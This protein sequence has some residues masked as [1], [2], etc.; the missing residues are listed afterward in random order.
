MYII[1]VAHFLLI[2]A[3]LLAGYQALSGRAVFGLTLSA[4]TLSFAGLFYAFIVSDF[5]VGLV[6]AHSHTEKP[7]LYKIA[8]V[9][10]NHEGSM[11]LWAWVLALFG[12]MMGLSH[13]KELTP[14]AQRVQSGLL[15]LFLLFIA[16]TS[17]P[18]WRQLP[19]PFEGDG[20][21]PLLQDPALAAHPPLLYLG[22]VGFSAVFSLAVAGLWHHYMNHPKYAKEWAA[23]ARPWALSAWTFLTVGIGLGSYW[24]YYEL[25]WG[26]W[27]FWDPVENAS[28]MPWLTGTALLHSI[29]VMS[30]RGLFARWVTFLSLVTFGLSLLGTFLVRSGVLISVHTFAADPDRGLFILLILAISVGGAFIL[31]A[32]KNRRETPSTHIAPV[33]KESVILL[34]N[35]VLF[36]AATTVLLGTLY[37]VMTDTLLSIGPPFYEATIL[38]MMIPIL[39]VCGLVPALNWQRGHKLIT[40]SLYPAV[41]SLAAFVTLVLKTEESVYGLFGIALGIWLIA[42]TLFQKLRPQNIGYVLGHVGLGVMVIGMV[43]SSLGQTDQI[44]ALGLGESLYLQNDTYTLA[45]VQKY[46]ADNYQAIRATILLN[47]ATPL[48]AEKRRYAS[49]SMETTEAGILTTFFKDR[50][51]TIGLL[52]KDEQA[53]ET[54][55]EKLAV[56]V[57][58]NPLMVWI[59]G[60]M[61]LMALGTTVQLTRH[62]FSVS[63]PVRQK[64][65]WPLKK[66]LTWQATGV[67]ILASVLI[68][69][70]TGRPFLKDIPHALQK[71]AV[72]ELLH[73]LQS[74]S[75]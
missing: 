23:L 42:G 49:P 56:R 58:H 70:Q 4:L 67:L 39:L 24:A 15:F 68:Y 25:G 66:G 16:L 43:A 28:L 46:E 7:L 2:L 48:M 55:P 8:G 69:S 62:S 72:G 3:L 11:M 53:D 27:W 17:N 41:I 54:A 47:S 19:P 35:V 32:L 20:L 74:D 73:H 29:M 30:K 71:Q 21:N 50:Y 10:G 26:G 18:F 65:Q 59:W 9:W 45:D 38:P 13:H 12:W 37:P 1:E 22:Y 51:V 64:P 40:L 5:S 61:I 52:P 44:K 60:G 14:T 57:Y 31:Y 34:N 33:S 63:S 6:M 75:F 36:A